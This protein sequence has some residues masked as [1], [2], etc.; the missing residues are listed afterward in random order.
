M[1]LDPLTAALDAG[2]TIIDKIWPDAGEAERQ[3][4]QMAKPLIFLTPWR[5]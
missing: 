5:C 3:K 2:K 4:V 1:A